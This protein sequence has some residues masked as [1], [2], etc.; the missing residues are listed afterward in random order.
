MLADQFS[1]IFRE[2][3][4]Q[5]RDVLL[6]LIQAFQDRNRER[7]WDLLSRGSAFIGPHF[8]YEEEG[9]YPALVE[10]YGPDQIDQLYREH[11]HAIQSAGKLMALADKPAY[12]D[13]DVA[14]ATRIVRSILPHV[15]GCDG[16]SVMVEKLPEEKVQG[17]LDLRDQARTE[18][19]DLFQWV[20]K[21]RERP[22]QEAP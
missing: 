5:V 13:E 1:Q 10:I 22:I 14:E 18:G 12:T 21:V 9:L 6:D 20:Q 7:V 2:E 3:H 17:I 15:S 16:L 8:R 4:R 11:D 19:L